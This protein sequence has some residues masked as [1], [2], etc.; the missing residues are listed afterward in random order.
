MSAIKKLKKKFKNGIITHICHSVF[1]S[2]AIFLLVLP[3][4]HIYYYQCL[5]IP[6]LTSAEKLPTTLVNMFPK[7][8]I[9]PKLM[10]QDIFHNF[11][12]LN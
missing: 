12:G 1:A 7:C 2:V 10:K 6:L 5:I 9:I 8:L 11:S 4:M 3:I